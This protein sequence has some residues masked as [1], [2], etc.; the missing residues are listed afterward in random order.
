MRSNQWWDRPGKRGALTR[1]TDYTHDLQ[2]L[3]TA[4]WD[5]SE[6]LDNDMGDDQRA[7]ARA[8][9]T[10]YF[11]REVDVTDTIQAI[12]GTTD[13]V[14]EAPAGY[15]VVQSCVDT[16]SNHILQ[17]KIRPMLLTE[18][19]NSEERERAE[20]MQE[21]IEAELFNAGLYGEAA[22]DLCFAGN[23][24][25]GGGMLFLPDFANSRIDSQL[26]WAHDFRI[27]RGEQRANKIQN[28]VH[29][30][31]AGVDRDALLHFFKDED[32]ETLE[33]I[34]NA[35]TMAEAQKDAN[36]DEVSDRVEVR[37]LWHF[38]SGRV[39]RDKLENWGINPKTREFDDTVEPEHD[40]RFVLAIRD[41]VLMDRPWPLKHTMAAWFKPRKKLGSAWSQGLPEILAA[42]QKSLNKWQRRIEGILELHAVPRLV[43]WNQA[44][45]KPTK[46]N[47]SLASILTSNRPPA[48]S[49]AVI[50][51][52]AVPRELV[53]RID[54]VIAY[55]E[56]KAGISELSIA[57]TKP[58]SIE[59]EPALQH[60]ADTESLRHT[61]VWQAWE[62]FYT[63]AG[64]IIIEC[65]RQLALF[66]PDYEVIFGND[67]EMKRIRWKDV[68]LDRDRYLIRVWPTNLLPKTPAA[69][70]KMVM[71]FLERGLFDLPTA[72]KALDYPDIEALMGDVIAEQKNIEKKLLAVKKGED[73]TLPSVAHAYLNLPLAKALCREA[74]NRAEADGE[75]EE[76]F[77]NL[78]E[79]FEQLQ[80]LEEIAAQQQ[81]SQGMAPAGGAPL[82]GASFAGTLPAAPG[83]APPPGAAAPMPPPAGAPV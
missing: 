10:L 46:F 25:D 35:P 41:R 5:Y 43:V 73:V 18:G 78:V 52:Q 9:L 39:D 11:G 14:D 1:G 81:M 17:N 62:R 82:Q 45:L 23:I 13:L 29:I 63:D 8:A 24:L 4:A 69:K 68:D 50:T 51:P 71:A 38:P 15:N 37:Q 61:R 58:P 21:L 79:F 83:G 32:E 34:R 7:R 20:G 44:K 36:R 72:L 16:L 66:D 19:G 3:S 49:F 26:V 40:G 47:N 74:I 60:L 76:V 28:V 27:P 65:I 2:D 56:K 33:A 67:K 22:G 31:S 42:E 64:E 80:T 77:D 53:E 70:A 30:P 6:R 75:P 12:F 48:Q 55:A 54:K 59:H 57:A